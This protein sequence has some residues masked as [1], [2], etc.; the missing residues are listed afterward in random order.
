MASPLTLS[1]SIKLVRIPASSASS[2]LS[3]HHLPPFPLCHF[4]RAV[5]NSRASF[6]HV[7]SP[8]EM[9][10]R[11]CVKPDCIFTKQR[12]KDRTEEILQVRLIMHLD[13]AMAQSHASCKA[14]KGGL[15]SLSIEVSL[16]STFFFLPQVVISQ[17]KEFI[18]KMTP[19]AG[20]IYKYASPNPTPE[21]SIPLHA[22]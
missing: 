5:S 20:V 7:L 3:F 18:F 22:N 4:P 16:S 12:A 9:C 15:T 2:S 8:S 10:V 19:A 21:T 14:C 11:V 13:C 1:R 17:G 6:T